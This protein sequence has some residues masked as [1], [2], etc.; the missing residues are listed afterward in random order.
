MASSPEGTGEHRCSSTSTLEAWLTS[1]SWGISPLREQALGS[2]IWR[3]VRD[4]G[5]F[6]GD[7]RIRPKDNG[8]SFILPE[9]STPREVK[10]LA[11]NTRCL[12]CVWSWERSCIRSRARHSDNHRG[13]EETTQGPQKA[14]HKPLKT[15]GLIQGN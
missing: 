13:H 12:P 4:R 1:P 6:R 2:G 9:P 8:C 11:D 3:S 5:F 15:M 7:Q 10:E 14:Q